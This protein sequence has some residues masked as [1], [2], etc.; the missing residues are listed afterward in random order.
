M[1]MSVTTGCE[2]E[3]NPIG[4]NAAR[5]L[6]LIERLDH[7]ETKLREELADVARLR[8]LLSANPEVDEILRILARK[9]GIRF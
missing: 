8:T 6:S 7:E 2:I 1:S 3:R 9:N 4:G 5:E